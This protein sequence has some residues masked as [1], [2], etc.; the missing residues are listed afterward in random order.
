MGIFYSRESTNHWRE[1]AEAY[2]VY[3]TLRRSPFGL[4]C[5]QER[6]KAEAAFRACEF[7]KPASVSEYRFKEIVHLYRKY[8]RRAEK[9]DKIEAF[10]SGYNAR[11]RKIE[12]VIKDIRRWH[13]ENEEL[14]SSPW[15]VVWK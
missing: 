14:A 3:V 4:E 8:I 13:D 2:D 15:K 12:E 7:L 5:T 10:A 6:L 9:L 1:C 11:V